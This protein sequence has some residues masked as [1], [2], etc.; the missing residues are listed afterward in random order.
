MTQAHSHIVL[1]LGATG[2]SVVRFLCA[3]G[4][5][6][7]V[8]DTRRNPPGQQELGRE[9]PDVPLLCGAFDC[10]LLIQA[11]QIVISPGIALDT[12]EVQAAVDIGVEV[13]GDIELFARSL[14]HQAPRVLAITGSNGKSTV[15]TLVGEILAEDGIRVGVGGNIGVPALNILQE[16]PDCYV[17]ELSSFQ[18]ETTSSLKCIAATCLNVSEDHMDRYADLQSYRQAKLRLYRQTQLRLVNRDD[19]LTLLDEEQS[20][21]WPKT[22]SISF[23]LD[24]PLDRGWGIVDNSIY[25]NE[26]QVIA[27]EEVSLI[28]RHN[29]ANLLAAMALAKEAGAS[30]QA[31]A[32]VARRFNGLAHRCEKVAVK[33]GVTYVNDSKATNVGATLAA[34]DGLQDFS[35]NLI[36]IAGGEGKGA[37]FCGLTPAFS[38]VAKLITL[39][40]DGAKLAALKDGAKQVKSMAEAVKKAA[41]CSQPGDMVLLSPACASLDMYKS[42]V[43]RG[44]DFRLLVEALDDD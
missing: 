1:G 3:Q 16:K 10:R 42:F 31:M 28:G 21:H 12:P 43:A 23:G 15:T 41:R 32:S 38:R 37:D 25:H 13:I 44:E 26:H 19:E 11:K 24:A 5:T 30:Y 9:F 33:K 22:P 34:L 18:L 29:H 36:L 4:I 17:L 27:L 20:H 40:K 14:E 6:P 39:G 8:M 7:L 35:G 2:I